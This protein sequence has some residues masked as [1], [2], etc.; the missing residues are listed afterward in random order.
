[1]WL[2]HHFEW[3]EI[4]VETARRTKNN[5]ATDE[6]AL[7]FKKMDHQIE[8]FLLQGNM[9]WE[10]PT[11]AGIIAGSAD[12]G[13]TAAIWDDTGGAYASVQFGYGVLTDAG[14]D[15]PFDILLSNNLRAG[16]A[17]EHATGGAVPAKKAISDSFEIPLDNFHFTGIGAPT[18]HGLTVNGFPAPALNDGRW[19]M[20]KSDKNNFQVLEAFAPKLTIVEAMDVKRRHF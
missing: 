7:A 3:S 18:I 10:V 2:G 1:M 8:R 12:A 4:E 16:L 17:K 9:A 20:M 11:N 13:A 6:I 15:G 14:F 5:I 19:L